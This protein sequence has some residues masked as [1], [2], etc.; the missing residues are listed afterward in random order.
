MGN[1]FFPFYNNDKNENPFGIPS[2][3]ANTP[4]QADFLNA[5]GDQGIF[6]QLSGGSLVGPDGPSF[7]QSMAGYKD[8]FGNM[9]GGWGGGALDL[10]NSGFNVYGGLKQLGLAE[11]Q[12][13]FQKGAFSKNFEAQAKS[14][15][16]ALEDR[17]RARIHNNPNGNFMSVE[18]YM[19]K[20][21]V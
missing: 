7:I 9:A 8:K 14:T 3:N 1:E 10:L 11:D 19:A 16:A 2:F 20:Y 6:S 5:V 15:N 21:G 17:Q 18:D 12:L 4:K 13:D